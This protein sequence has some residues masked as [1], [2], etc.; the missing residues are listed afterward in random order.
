MRRNS[1]AVRINTVVNWW[2]GDGQSVVSGPW[3]LIALASPRRDQN[4]G[5][6]GG[7]G[8]GRMWRTEITQR[9]TIYKFS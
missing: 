5:S 8:I 1:P 9:K 2:S 6:A 7:N 4:R 3:G